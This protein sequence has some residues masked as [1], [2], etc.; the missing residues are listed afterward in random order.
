LS[1]TPNSDST[2]VQIDSEANS[3]V[4]T[5]WER[6]ATS[7]V[8]VLKISNDNGKTFREIFKLGANGTIGS[9]GGG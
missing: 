5:W 2:R 3:L 6:N 4:V 7:N 8:P 9:S 1:N